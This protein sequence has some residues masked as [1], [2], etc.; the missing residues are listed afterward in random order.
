MISCASGQ[1]LRDVVREK[2][3]ADM[4]C[5]D[6]TMEG[7]LELVKE[8]R[9]LVPSAYIILIASA[10]ISPLVYMRPTVAAQSLLLKPL[11]EKQI[12]A[13]LREAVESYAAR[14]Y[15]P[16]ESRMFV[17]E[18]GGERSLID[19]G[20]ICFFEARDKRVYLNT[21]SE[22]YGFYDT[23]EQLEEKL[24]G[25]FLRCHRSFLVNKDKIEHVFLSQNRIVLS[26][27]FEVPLS[28][29]YKPAMKEYLTGVGQNS[30]NAGSGSRAALPEKEEK[31]E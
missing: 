18:S 31:Y 20:R 29:S 17:V 12:E 15:Q 4:L 19:Y 13:V 27:E 22:E 2:S 30:G 16:D 28:R 23:L 1:E 8:L 21:E 14:F 26:G 25:A 3:P 10:E 9:L 6:I 11:S 24:G 7:A 5:V